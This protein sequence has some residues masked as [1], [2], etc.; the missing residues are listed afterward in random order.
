MTFSEL[1]DAACDNP[2]SV[3]IPAEWSQG[4]ACFG[5]LMAAL[6]YE[7]MR[8]QVPEGRPIRSL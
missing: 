8:K 5:G 1:I 7:A 4:R 2:G 6:T 3:T